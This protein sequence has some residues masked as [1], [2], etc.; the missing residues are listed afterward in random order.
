M[1][2]KDQL[3]DYLQRPY[4]DSQSFLE[5]VIFPVFGEEN[6][7]DA[8]RLNVLR[9]MPEL[10]PKAELSGITSILNLGG[11]Y[12]DGSQLDIFD[13]TV[14]SKRQLARSRVDIQEI[15]RRII[16]NYAGAFMIFHYETMEGRWDW[17]FTFC[18]KGANQLDSTDAKRYTFLLGPGQSC[19]T[20][21]E[22][23]MKL[24]DNL[25]RK[26][27]LEIDDIVSA[28][29]V[30]ALS[31]E[32]F[33]KYKQHYERF[34][35]FV[36]D[37]KNDREWFGEEFAE[38]EDKYI[39]D[40]VKRMMGRLVF[41]HFMQKKGWM[42]VPADKQW[43][44]GDVQFALH[45]YRQAS[46][47]QQ[48]N[49][50]DEI[51]EPLFEDALD[52]P[53]TDD[54]YDTK[55]EGFRSVKIPFLGGGLFDKDSMDVPKSR[56][57]KEYFADLLE[58]FYEYNFTI[59]EN[60]PNDAQ[61]GIDPEM[62]GMIF[63]NLLEDNKDKGA[64]YTP[65]EI[66]Q[67]MC[68]ESL[69]A[70][71]Q[72]DAADDT[73]KDAIRQF[74]TTH[75]VAAI[76]GAG[77]ELAQNIS[78]KLREVKICDP[79]IGSGAFPMGLLN[80]LFLCRGAI[81]NFEN[82]AD[83][84]RHIIQKNIYGVDIEK[85][86][87]DIAR[88]RFW[89]SLIVDAEE[90]TALPSMDFKIMQGNSL[91]EQY[92]GADLSQLVATKKKKQGNVQMTLFEDNVDV[93]RQQ[94]Y[95]LM[96]N[97]YNCS[98][99]DQRELIRQSIKSLINMQLGAQFIS[100]VDMTN[101]DIAGNSEF[102]LWHTWFADVFDKGGFDIVIGNPPYIQLQ[103]DGGLLASV[104]DKKGFETFAKSGDIYCLFYEQG[105]NLLKEHG[106]LCY[107]TSD[108]WM[109]AGYGEKTRNFFAS[110]TN[111]K[112]LVDFDG[113][114]IFDSATVVTNILLFS[115][116]NNA[117]KTL[118]SSTHRGDAN[119]TISEFLN[120]KQ[121]IC[122]FLTKDTW[123]ILDATQQ[124]LNEKIKKVGKPLKDWNINMYRG[125]LTGF[126]DA[127]IISTEKRNE[128]LASCSTDDER[129]RTDQ[130]IRPILRGRDISRYSYSW[131]NLWLINTHNG[132]KKKLPRIE[133]DE[134]PAI[135]QHLDKYIEQLKK[136]ADKGDTPYNL[137]NCAYVEDFAKPKI[138]WGN[139]NAQ[140]SYVWAEEDFYINAPSPI[141][142]PASKYL[143]GALNSKVADY[144]IRQL[145]VTRNGGYFEYKPMFVEKI[146]IPDVSNTT[147]EKI[148]SL[149]DNILS[150]KKEN[151]HADTS[152]L[153]HEI[154]LLVY[155]LY[156]LTP[157]EIVIVEGKV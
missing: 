154:D 108:K 77:A 134:Y 58:F 96:Q 110:K 13:I 97:Y 48:D 19:R 122:S 156:G 51:L 57:P 125:L 12:V 70:Y 140:G 114:N 105:F 54:L 26:G 45:L 87:V 21:A 132:V 78:E 6:F 155:D 115:K 65:K 151:P 40:Y 143:L 82:A 62:L 98:S 25:E 135:K 67:Y 44:D 142:V 61:V 22:N 69:I 124:V 131:A 94:L 8:G 121:T 17:R 104:Y 5:N 120:Q 146:P 119:K 106:H 133:I 59:D 147:T 28:F 55:V 4:V 42:G 1:K 116:D 72:T 107:I 128:I 3:K 93:L 88:L 31:K 79:A 81:E 85:G 80:E 14:S 112:L 83:I 34:C 153:E 100:T 152:A 53:R 86:A 56:F 35:Q 103:N 33:Q 37:N 90:P 39:R 15:V 23:F 49:F 73:T 95:A 150:A 2:L 9:K 43:G 138:V 64:F 101:I 52:T 66:V 126:N 75:D 139:L 27:E 92:Q 149:V 145:G 102:F 20:A 127:F 91:L 38:W 109:R 41:I 144:Y 11:I 47:A 46:E 117:G 50:L 74:V 29:D 129:V 18:R 157:E 111:P 113:V 141:I 99:H 30:E 10:K 7:E 130:L 84:K 32:F 63:E 60:D 76:D 24:H 68:R 137:R 123:T 16:S 148:E 89:L 71:L 118:C 136:R 36:Y